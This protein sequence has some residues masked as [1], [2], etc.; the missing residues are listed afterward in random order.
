MNWKLTLN[1]FLVL[2]LVTTFFFKVI[3]IPV[4]NQEGVSNPDKF[5]FG[6]FYYTS[7]LYEIQVDNIFGSLIS[8]SLFT[9][10]FVINNRKIRRKIRRKD[11]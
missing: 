1:I 9:M 7:I 11:G 2:L 6:G 4:E 10:M 5:I 3:P 8:F